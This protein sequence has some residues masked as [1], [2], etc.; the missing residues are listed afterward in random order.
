MYLVRGWIYY[1]TSL[2]TL[3][4]GCRTGRCC[5]AWRATGPATG[6]D[7]ARRH[8]YVVRN[9]MD[10][11][12][13]KETNLDRDYEVFGAAIQD[14]WNIVDI[15][16]AMG[17]FT[18][19]AARQARAGQG[20]RRTSRRPIRWR[21]SSAT[22]S[23]TAFENVE[24]RQVAVSAKAGVM[25]LDVSGGVAV[26]YSTVG[27]TS[28]S[29]KE[30]HRAQP[31]AGGGAGRA[32]ERRLRFPEDGLRRCR[33][34]HAAQPGRRS[35]GRIRRI[36]LEYHECVTPYSHADLAEIFEAKG[37]AVRVSPSRVRRELGFLYAERR[38]VS[39]LS[40]AIAGAMSRAARSM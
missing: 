38:L 27:E 4:R 19:F 8:R 28:A 20:V 23:S 35:L 10:V 3:A 13:I 1:L 37:W 29:Q 15:G 40:R 11:W 31:G 24:V 5:S 9:L 21:C 36:C 17:D 16:A 18:I 39:S 22:C 34:R 2:F 6:A 32:A 30:D 33:V 7:P 14:G 25:S 12:T 26:Q